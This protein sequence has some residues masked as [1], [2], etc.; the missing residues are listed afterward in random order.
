[1]IVSALQLIAICI[2]SYIGK[3]LDQLPLNGPQ[4]TYI[5]SNHHE[6]ILDINFMRICMCT[7]MCVCVF[8]CVRA[9]M[10]VCVCARVSTPETINNYVAT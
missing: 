1:M 8:A 5:I 10:C 9:C 6:Y 2:A 3:L 7:C 4:L